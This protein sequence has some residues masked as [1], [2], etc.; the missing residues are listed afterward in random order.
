M[1]TIRNFSRITL[2]IA[3]LVLAISAINAA[4]AT[5]TVTNTNDAGAG[6]LRDAITQANAAAGADTIV[7]SSLFNSAQTIQLASSLPNYN[8]AD[9]LTITGPGS[10]LL[11]I[12]GND[13]FRIFTLTTNSIVTLSGL[14][15]TKGRDTFLGGGGIFKQFGTLSITNVVVTAN[16]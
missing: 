1:Q 15:I 4:A 9:P 10:N 5:F 13:T 7:F 6:S 14:T 12:R 16:T 3:I 8:S 11:T 2:T